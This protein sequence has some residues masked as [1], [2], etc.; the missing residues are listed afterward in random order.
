V[1]L[2][3]IE[4][5]MKKFIFTKYYVRHFFIEKSK[6][7]FKGNLMEGD[8]FGD[9]FFVKHNWFK[10]EVKGG[11]RGCSDS[12]KGARQMYGDFKLY[13]LGPFFLSLGQWYG[14]VA[15][16]PEMGFT[17]NELGIMLFGRM[18]TISKAFNFATTNSGKKKFGLQ[19]QYKKVMPYKGSEKIEDVEHPQI[20]R[21]IVDPHLTGDFK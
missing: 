11:G 18:F 7:S 5:K 13:F 4:I 2:G 9:L 14:W 12:N 6:R 19:L 8:A 16:H 20:G 10:G 17:N 1:Y 21:L 15:K 3:R